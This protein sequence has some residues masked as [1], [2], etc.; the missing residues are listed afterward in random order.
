MPAPTTWDPTVPHCSEEARILGSDGKDGGGHW[1][2]HFVL[3]SD[4]SCPNAANHHDV[5]VAAR[6][7]AEADIMAEADRREKYA[8]GSVF[9]GLIPPYTK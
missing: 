1:A 4:G 8:A 2:C 5:Y 9:D 7:A 3:N 6:Y